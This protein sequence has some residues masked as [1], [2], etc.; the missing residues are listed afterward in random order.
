MQIIWMDK[1]RKYCNKHVFLIAQ[2]LIFI[3]TIYIL[4]ARL[5]HI[6]RKQYDETM[7]TLTW[8]IGYTPLT[9]LT[10]LLSALRSFN[11]LL[12]HQ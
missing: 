3:Y 4:Y 10:T 5:V 7:E 2:K 8:S 12:Y 1:N 6:H 9:I 11:M